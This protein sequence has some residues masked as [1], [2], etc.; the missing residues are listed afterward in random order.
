MDY[1]RPVRKQSDQD[2]L[3]LSYAE[4]PAN[5]SGLG[6][7]SFSEEAKER[8]EWYQDSGSPTPRRYQCR[9][10]NEADRIEHAPGKG[11]LQESPEVPV[12]LAPQRIGRQLE[13]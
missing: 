13:G 1:P 3:D 12:W 7:M 2:V 11:L 4:T 9:I 5:T 10:L 8:I 6:F